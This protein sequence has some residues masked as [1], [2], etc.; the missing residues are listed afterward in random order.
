VGKGA[1]LQIFRTCNISRAVAT[2]SAFRVGKTCPRLRT[3]IAIDAAYV[4]RAYRRARIEA[5]K[6]TGL[7]KNEFPDEC[8]YTWNDFVAR[9]FT[10]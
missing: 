10:R 4:A 1:L 5:A 2:C 7:E 9:E 6:E 3:G 8:P